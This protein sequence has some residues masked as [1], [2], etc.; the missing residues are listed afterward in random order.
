MD[1]AS[2]LRR[3]IIEQSLKAHPDPKWKDH[4]HAPL[5]DESRL[6]LKHL[7]AY[8]TGIK[9]PYASRRY[10]LSR[11][12]AVLVALF[13]G[14][15]GD[16]YVLLSRRSDDLR[17][18]AGDTSLPGGKRD[19]EDKSPEDTARREA[20]E[21]IGLPRDRQRIPL[22]CT[23]EPF[24]STN[25]LIVF[26]VVVLITDPAIKPALNA[27]EVAA[28]FSHPLRSLLS[29]TSPFPLPHVPHSD[30]YYSITQPIFPQESTPLEDGTDATPLAHPP[31]HTHRDYDTGPFH[32]QVRIHSFLTGREPD[33]KP[34]F[35]LTAAILVR[36]ALIGYGPEIVPEFDVL[37]PD[38]LSMKDR[39]AFA[40]TTVPSLAEA[41]KKEGIKVK[42]IQ[43][44]LQR[45]GSRRG[46][47]LQSRL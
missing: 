8:T 9:N 15:W 38:Q 42:P 29:A 11:S 10:P 35:G 43:R 24:L 36:V 3:A 31:Y 46:K 32:T 30:S 39:I 19:P 22:L 21:E 14:R 12:A 20:L 27:P 17:S 1:G 23:L 37:A 25:N 34:L 13:V 28:L 47:R 18:Y 41:C 7:A 33:I 44:D 5:K 40:L 26:P 6:C 2:T 45:N 16:L 4:Y